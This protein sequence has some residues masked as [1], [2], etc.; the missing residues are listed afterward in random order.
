MAVFIFGVLI[1]VFIFSKITSKGFIIPL[2]NLSEGA[3]AIADGDYGRQ[4]EF[5]DFNVNNEIGD[6]KDA[7]NTM[8]RKLNEEIELKNKADANRRQL[9]LDIAHD[10]KNPITSAMGYSELLLKED[11]SKDEIKRYSSIIHNNCKRANMLAVTLF[12]FSHLQR[13]GFNLNL[14]QEDICEFMREVIA[15][16]IPKIEDSSFVYEFSIPDEKISVNIDNEHLYRA[17]SNILDNSIEYNKSGTRLQISISANLCKVDNNKN[18]K[19]KYVKITIQDNGVGIPKDMINEI[20]NPFVR[21]DKAR[22]SATGGAG[23]GL[24]I[25]KMIVEKHDGNI[26]LESSEGNGCRFVVVLPIW[27]SL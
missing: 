15:D 4:V 11:I 5:K 24:A 2:K 19:E 26:E 1:S 21:V 14:K 20:F 9:I 17:V 10:L 18:D 3:I 16:Y 13:E 23:L 22:N 27:I 6:L 8:S 25:A 12:E 7:F